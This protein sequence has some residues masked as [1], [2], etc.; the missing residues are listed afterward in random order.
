MAS[1]L[2]ASQLISDLKRDFGLTNEQAAGVVGNLMYES[3][4]FNSLQEVN[5]TVPGSKGGFG[6]AQWTGD[7]RKSFESY[8][9]DRGLDKNSYDANYGFLKHELQTDPYERRQFNTVKRADTAEEAARLISQNYLRPG[10]P[11]LGERQNLAARAL[12]FSSIPIPPGSLPEVATQLDTKRPAV[13]PNPA[14]QSPVMTAR[15]NA[16]PSSRMIQD[17]LS[18]VASVNP[19][20][21]SLGDQIAM[22]PIQGGRQTVAPFDAA[23]D[24]RTGQMRMTKEPY[25][26]FGNDVATSRA[27]APTPASVDDRINARNLS[28]QQPT[29]MAALSRAPVTYA[30]QDNNVMRRA[31]APASVD[32]RLNARNLAQQQALLPEIPA[33]APVAPV[34]APAV[35]QAAIL[36]SAMTAS[37]RARAAQVGIKPVP[38][39]LP[40]EPMMG[41]RASAPAAQPGPWSVATLTDTVNPLTGLRTTAPAAAPVMARAAPNPVS[42]PVAPV[43]RS[44]IAQVQPTFGRAPLQ[45]NVSGANVMRAPSVVGTSTGRLYTPGATVMLNGDRLTVNPNGSFTNERTGNEL[46]GSSSGGRSLVETADGMQWR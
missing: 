36:P 14:S 32:D 25:A 34:S 26:G 24:T 30:A 13:A 20:T 21:A 27:P 46:R 12:G 15:R 10:K 41:A 45:I 33:S 35:A 37:D 8:V 18:R 1:E 29:G 3:G 31:P 42:R 28:Q 16:T 17:S 22:A 39:R 11:N 5:P 7:R 43:M 4:G 38:E 2:I 40:S 44:P 23:F 19:R 9:K 6:Y